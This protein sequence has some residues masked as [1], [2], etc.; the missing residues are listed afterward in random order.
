MTELHGV[1]QRAQQLERDSSRDYWLAVLDASAV[2]QE[3]APR[4]RR[5]WLDSVIS[6]LTVEQEGLCGICRAP[7]E[8]PS[9]VDHIIPFC[10]GGGNERSNIQLAHASCNRAK[11]KNV[12]PRDLLRYLEDRFM[13]R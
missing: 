13:N 1:L 10:Y 4:Q 11:G 8:G 2:L 9:E 12:A 5:P 6:D 3:I 7:L